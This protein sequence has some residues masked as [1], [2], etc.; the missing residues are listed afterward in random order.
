MGFC[1]GGGLSPP[2]QGSHADPAYA[3][4]YQAAMA[5]RGKLDWALGVSAGVFFGQSVILAFLARTNDWGWAWLIS[6]ILFGAAVA[7]WPRKR[8]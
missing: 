1:W 3:A 7:I 2:M 4:G 6:G 5:E 8:H